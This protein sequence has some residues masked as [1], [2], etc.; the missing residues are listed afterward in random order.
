VSDLS[1]GR[2]E[3]LFRIAAGGM[4]EVYAARIRGEAGFQKLVAVKRMLPHLADDPE[5]VA[6]FLD[7]GRLA[8][9][10]HSPHVV[11]T[12]DLGKA[13]DGS[14]YIVMDLVV[15]IALSTLIR[16]AAKQQRMLPVPIACEI[17]A[18]AASGLDDAHEARTPTGVHLG[19]V[20]R[21]VSPQNVLVGVDGRTRVVDFGV[22]R[23]VLRQ[24]HTSTGTLKGKFAYFSPEQA[25][26][27]ELDPRSDVFALGIVA[28]ETLL[29]RRLFESTENPLETITRIRSMP[30]PRPSAMRPEIPELVSDVIMRALNRDRDS[31]WE[32]AGAF[33]TA[34]RAAIGA[35][36]T[37]REV[38]ALVGDVA[39]PNVH[40][41]Q[42]R[43][44]AA[45]AGEHLV[46][47]PIRTPL[48]LDEPVMTTPSGIPAHVADLPTLVRISAPSE[49][50]ALLS[51]LVVPER[52]AGGTNRWWIAG[53]AAAAVIVV[54]IGVAIASQSSPEPVASP[55]TPSVRDEPPPIPVTTIAAP[56][57]ATTVTTLTSPP[58]P[59]T[60][61]AAGSD[62]VPRPT[63]VAAP[64]PLSDT[65]EVPT[66]TVRTPP[67]TTTVRTPPPTSVV[68]APP[69]STAQRTHD[70][71]D[72]DRHP[73]GLAGDD[74]FDQGI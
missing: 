49:P 38:A 20:H 50:I 59:T 73:A 27:R 6:M 18:Q 16:A 1:F 37:S 64:P 67:P 5:F 11:S 23:A 12:I 44:E 8:A 66:T 52:E 34:L 19:I 72:D 71:H 13:D 35:P 9:N 4:A 26:A 51:T 2:Y 17:I 69:P 24:S 10:I 47:K 74:A 60:R 28:W 41:M 63:R 42:S 40:E 53:L 43:I 3:P 39:G 7:E 65:H 22:A 36:V 15:G 68:S 30:I 55:L 46:T 14:L 29:A 61:V 21:D 56:P 57:E 58:P 48:K 25:A 45:M 54:V 33:A 62:R 31:R 70:T 32:S